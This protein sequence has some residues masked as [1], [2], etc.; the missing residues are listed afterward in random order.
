[1]TS[2]EMCTKHRRVKKKINWALILNALKT[3]TLIQDGMQIR[4]QVMNANKIGQQQSVS[5]HNIRGIT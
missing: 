4:N 5:R 2:F 1:M 3:S